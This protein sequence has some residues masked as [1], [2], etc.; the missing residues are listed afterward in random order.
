[1]A[2]VILKYCSP[3]FILLICFTFACKHDIPEQPAP[4]PTGGTTGGGTGNPGTG[5]PGTGNPGTGNPGTGNPVT[6]CDPNVVYFQRDVLPILLSN[7]TMS[8]CHNATDHQDG[9]I[10]DNYTNVMAT[11]DV[12]PGNANNSDLYEVLVESDPRKRMP[13]NLPQLP[14]A[15]RTIIRNWINQGAKNETCGTASCD[16]LNVTYTATIQPIIQAN[17]SGCHNTSL[18]SGGYNFNTHAGLA[19]AAQNGRLVGA[20]AQKTGFKSMPQ[21]GRLTDCQISQIRNWVQ[22]GALNN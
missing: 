14:V 15:Q 13:Y 19:V 22:K 20:V 12:R 2:S 1:M 8:G 18:A 10:L 4:A 16:S 21:G 7:C 17:C 3:V 11:A 5:N 9:V 6:P